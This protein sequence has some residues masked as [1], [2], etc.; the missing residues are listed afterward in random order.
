MLSLL[1]PSV[2]R[3]QQVISEQEMAVN[4]TPSASSVPSARVSG[5]LVQGILPAPGRNG[6]NN[7]FATDA[8]RQRTAIL[9][10]PGSQTKSDARQ[11]SGVMW[12]EASS[13]QTSGKGV[14][15][16]FGVG[17]SPYRTLGFAVGP[18]VQLNGSLGSHMG[19]STSED[20]DYLV[21]PT[22]RH[23]STLSATGFAAEQGSDSA[24]L[25]ASLSYMPF[26]DLWIGIHGRLTSDLTSSSSN[27][28]DRFDAMLGL[29]A[30]YRLKF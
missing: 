29:T 10:L 25:A 22:L 7:Y 19:M 2:V 21:T 14:S 24:G 20:D 5:Y 17:Y 15:A 1:V 8:S 18:V 13:D 12:L 23:D 9:T 27:P 6:F 3:A 4:S 16:Q 11:Q 26:E 28:T 30:G